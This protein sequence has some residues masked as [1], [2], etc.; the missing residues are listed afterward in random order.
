[1]MSE[2]HFHERYPESEQALAEA[3]LSARHQALEPSPKLTL[4]EWV[5]E[6][7]YLSG[8]S[9]AE[10]GKFKPFGYQVGL[11]EGMT[12]PSA[13]TVVFQK[14]TRVGYTMV[15]NFLVGYH[16]EHDP[17]TVLFV[18]PTADNVSEWMKD[19]YLPMIRDTPALAAISGGGTADDDKYNKFTSR[20]SVLRARGAYSA[21]TFRRV[22]SRINIGDEIDA[23]GWGT[24]GSKTQGD[25]L[26]LLNERGKTYWNRKLILGS[27]PLVKGRSRIETQFLRGD[28]RRYF[29][30]CP[31]CTEAN[32]GE[33]DGWQILQWG[34]GVSF[35]IRYKDDP[36]NPEYICRHCGVGIEETWKP[37]M[38]ARGEWRPTAQGE[39]GVISYH[40]SALYSLFPNAGWKHLVQ[41]WLEAKDNPELLQPFVNNV[42]GETFE[43]KTNAKRHEPHELQ[44]RLVREFEAEV[45]QGVRLITAGVDV[46]SKDGGRF[47]VSFYGWGAGERSVCLSHMILDQYLLK[48]PEAW[49]E[50]KRVLGRGFRMRDGRLLRAESV[51]V[52]H[53][54]HYPDDVI[55]FC[56]KNAHRNWYAVKGH[57]SKGKGTRR[58]A[59]R[60]VPRMT[61]APDKPWS[62]DVNL[63]KD[64]IF[65]RL[66]DEPEKPGGI[67]FP[68]SVPEGSVQFDKAFFTRLTREKQIPVQGEPG[69]FYWSSP[70]DQEPWD[71]L[72]YAYAAMV[73]LKS[74]SKIAAAKVAPQKKRAAP[75]KSEPEKAPSE[76]KNQKPAASTAKPKPKR[77]SPRVRVARY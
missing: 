8:E 77:K 59:D 62:I 16:L 13:H 45:P 60:I 3:L 41:E 18:L 17:T 29:V 27:T 42:L 20:G 36:E 2:A 40:I 19:S 10:I 35:G 32:G 5:E 11:M 24:G 70:Q 39:P 73:I 55:D 64:R 58:D 22:T 67:L 44:E 31:H 72:V 14:G 43:L 34:D 61:P 30:P 56:S 7:G 75:E 47:E 38:D 51:G 1:M 71:C 26:K 46:Q 23:D 48:D 6:H 69:A 12:D 74:R 66:H 25:K 68:D 9:S 65:Q 33:L 49:E 15:A 4:P 21:D 50:L 52:D 53:G 37:W 28:Q 76:T 54:G 63:I 57:G